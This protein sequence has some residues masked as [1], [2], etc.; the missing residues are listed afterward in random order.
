[1]DRVCVM[2]NY[3]V[4][5]SVEIKGESQ[6]RKLDWDVVLLGTKNCRKCKWKSLTIK[7]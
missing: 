7:L 5:Q 2:C 6:R 1:M 4:Y 3:V